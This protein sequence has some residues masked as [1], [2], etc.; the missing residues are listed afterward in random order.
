MIPPGSKI[1][2]LKLSATGLKSLDGIGQAKNLSRLIASNNRI[3]GPLPEELF[4]LSE[5]QALYLS[6]NA[7]SGTLSTRIGELTKL[8]N[9]YVD[10]NEFS[11][12]IPSHFGRLL[13]LNNLG[14]FC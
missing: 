10:D 4:S 6:Y 12:T 2:T 5:L 8:V 1:E 11:G 14:K 9:F 13:D 3:T 7:L